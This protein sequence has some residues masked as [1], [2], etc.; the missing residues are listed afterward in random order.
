MELLKSH[1]VN[2]IVDVRSVPAV[3]LK[4]TIYITCSLGM[5]TSMPVTANPRRE[6]QLS[7]SRETR[8]HKKNN[9]EIKMKK[10]SYVAN[11]INKNHIQD[12]NTDQVLS[13]R[14]Q[15]RKGFIEELALVLT[16]HDIMEEQYLNLTQQILSVVQRED[17]SWGKKWPAEGDEVIRVE[18]IPT[19]KSYN[20]MEAFADSIDDER[21][22]R[23]LYQALEER[24]PFG[25][26]RYAAERTGVIQ[27]WYDW[28]SR[29]QDEQA[30]EWMRENGVDFKDGRIV[31]DGKHTFIWSWDDEEY[32]CDNL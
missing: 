27:Q 32:G 19:W 21:I 18:K 17:Y 23:Q 14:K 8:I 3:G 12:S 2:C 31:A 15:T 20:Q 24:H 9:R 28:R 1:D 16:D 13:E 6:R 4:G 30:E 5:L 22:S 7:S 29:W 10:E 11:D 26:F 25:E